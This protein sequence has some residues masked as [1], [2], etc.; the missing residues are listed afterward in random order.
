MQVYAISEMKSKR[1]RII[2]KKGH[3]Y[4]PLRTDEIVLFYTESKIV[5]A[6]D[7]DN[8]KYFCDYTLFELES[9]LDEKIFFRANRQ[10]IIN[11]NYVK[12]F[13]SLQ[14]VKTKVE[15]NIAEQN[16]SIVVSQIT[17]PDFRKW[18]SEA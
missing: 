3:K 11:I 15:M 5:F 17:T 8:I 18:I 13:H 7:K 2:L 1:S 6:I 4:M 9:M 16:H 14:R 10:Y 12:A